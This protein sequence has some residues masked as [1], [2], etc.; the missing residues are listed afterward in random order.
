MHKHPLINAQTSVRG[1]V[2]CIKKTYIR[3]NDKFWDGQFHITATRHKHLQQ[4]KKITNITI[5]VLQ[6]IISFAWFYGS[7]NFSLNFQPFF[8]KCLWINGR[9]TN[10]IIVQNL[11]RIWILN[12]CV[13][14]LIYKPQT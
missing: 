6:E 13:F 12:T 1:S 10:G 8:K 9:V 4:R 14:Y 5:E 3:I 7:Q 11:R 2:I